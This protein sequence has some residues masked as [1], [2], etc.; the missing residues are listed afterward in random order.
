MVIIK[1]RMILKFSMLKSIN[2]ISE[3]RVRKTYTSKPVCQK[4]RA[5]LYDRPVYIYMCMHFY[6]ICFIEGVEIVVYMDTK[7]F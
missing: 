3:N 7:H 4:D 1:F 5:E 6:N 2:F